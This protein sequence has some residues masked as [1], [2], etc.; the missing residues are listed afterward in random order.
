[1]QIAASQSAGWRR[2]KARRVFVSKTISYAFVSL[3]AI[4]FAA[5]FLWMASMSLQGPQQLTNYPPNLIPDPAVYRNY[6]DAMTYPQRPFHIYF[7][8]SLVFTALATL[9]TVVSSSVVAFGFSR[10]RFKYR[11][12]LFIMVLSTMI[13]LPM[14]LYDFGALVYCASI[15]LF[16][17]EAL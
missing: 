17:I 9:G 1:M 12:T 11:E 7:K 6:W 3:L 2:Q 4:V 8:N 14:H 15:P 16:L 5:P 13:E 10:V